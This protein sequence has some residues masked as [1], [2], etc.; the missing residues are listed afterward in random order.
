MTDGGSSI[1]EVQALLRVLA[2]GRRSTE[3]GTAFG[4]GA[5]AMVET[6]TSV[7]T[8][9]LDAER[10]AHARRVLAG[11][12]HV[13]LVEGDWREVLPGREPFE[14]VF[15]DSTFKMAPFEE[16]PLIVD[17]LTPGELLVIDD[18]TSDWS[19]PDPAR[20]FIFDSDELRAVELRTTETTSILIASRVGQPAR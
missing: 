11:L 18:M 8:V 13:E 3:L 15:V 14:F 1:P 4:E 2:A 17:L 19:G 10:A 20:E 12:P 9:E 7:L 16:G 5:K 6:A